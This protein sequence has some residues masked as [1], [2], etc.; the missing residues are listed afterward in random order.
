[1]TRLYPAKNRAGVELSVAGNAR[2]E[3]LLADT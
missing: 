1:M 2:M 3:I